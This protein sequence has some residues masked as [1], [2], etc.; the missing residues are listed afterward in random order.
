MCTVTF[1]P[2]SPTTF[3]VTSNR[4]ERKSRPTIPPKPYQHK[5]ITLYF[6]KDEEA[7]GTWFAVSKEYTVVLLNGADTRHERNPPYRMSRGLVMLDFFGF[8]S[9]QDFTN[10]YNFDNIEPFTLVLIKHLDNKL[11]QFRWDG[12]TPSL[13]QMDSTSPQIWSSSTLY[14][15]AT[16][17][18]RKNWFAQWQKE[19]NEYTVDNILRFHRFGGE[20]DTANDLVMNRSDI[21]QTVSITSFEKG[22]NQSTLWYDDLVNNERNQLILDF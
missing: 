17:E 5:N 18:K 10:N 8:L 3:I 13:I 11:H 19:G 12:N 14:D 15:D 1:L 6:P 4:D 7:G 22:N 2:L 20:G 16:R 21:V 9:P